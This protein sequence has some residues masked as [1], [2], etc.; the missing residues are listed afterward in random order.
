VSGPAPDRGAIAFAEKL[1]TVLDQGRRTSTYKLA[2]VLGLMDLCLEHSTRSGAAPTSVSTRDLAPRVLELYWG[3][4]Q[5][6]GDAAPRVLRQNSDGQAEIITAIQRFR[7]QH[8]PDPSATRARARAHAPRAFE[9]LV[10]KVEWKLVE[11]PL[12]RLQVVGNAN[13][14]FLYRIGWNEH[15]RQSEF[16]SEQ[17]DPTIRFIGEAGEHL[18]RLAGLLRPFVQR[19]WVRLVGQWNGDLV[20]DSGLEEFLFGVPRAALAAVR[21]DLRIVDEGRC[22]YCGRRLGERWHVDHFV[23]WARHPDNGLENLVSAD[24]T[25][26]E[27]KSDHLAAVEHVEHWLERGEKRRDDLASIAAHRQWDR[28]PERSLGVARSIYLR[29]PADARLW[30]MSREFVAPDRRRLVDAFAGARS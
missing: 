28:H 16:A 14:P 15:V 24:E 21:D 22:F 4:A 1:L 12:P 3:H 29:L 9:R 23:P 2:V 11:M 17:F 5:K 6:F 27:R 10:R 7:A 8:A 25:C 13:E 26:N 18:V 30:R 19:E 20:R